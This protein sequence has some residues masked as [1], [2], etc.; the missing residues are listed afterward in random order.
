MTPDLQKFNSDRIKLTEP[1][2]RYFDTD[3]LEYRS[4]SSFFKFFEETF[5]TEGQS[6][7]TARK[8]LKQLGVTIT[9][10]LLLE[11]QQKVKDNWS[12]IGTHASDH[13]TRI[14]NAL[15][16]YQKFG[17]CPDYPELRTDCQRILKQFM[18]YYKSFP[19]K[20]VYL[21]DLP[22]GQYAGIAGTADRIMFRKN[23]SN[24]TVDIIDYKTNIRKGIQFK[25]DYGKYFLDPINHLENCNY[26]KYALQLS[27]YA[28]MLEATYGFKIG[29]LAILFI[30]KDMKDT[31]IPVP[32]MKWEIMQMLFKYAELSKNHQEQQEDTEN[33]F[34]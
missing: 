31:R 22:F 15:D 33:P 32:Y 29:N 2:H 13:G 25:S 1:G 21:E 7:A 34:N 30:D 28:Y 26:N 4:Q 27:M 10:E 6:L 9:P 5:D 18:G 17:D 19:E 16:Q 3:G 24:P 12:G 11:E 14:H 20:V 23:S 8:Q